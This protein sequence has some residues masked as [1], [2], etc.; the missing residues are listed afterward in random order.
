M[1]RIATALL[2]AGLALPL[3][4]CFEGPAGPPGQPGPR[5]DK[6]DPG[7]A[8]PAGPAGPQGAQGVQGPQGPAGPAG[9]A[10]PGV[11][12]RVVTGSGQ[13]RCDAGERIASLTCQTPAGNATMTTGGAGEAVGVCQSSGG[14]NVPGV[15]ICFK[16]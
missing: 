12:F 2:I 13:M 10:G 6:G 14:D 9:P 11:N 3:A 1:K 8:G 5:G 15:M 4:G 16:P 7:A